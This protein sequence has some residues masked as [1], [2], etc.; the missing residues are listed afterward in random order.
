MKVAIL[1]VLVATSAASASA[2]VRMSPIPTRINPL[3]G[4]PTLLPSPL[5]GPLSG[6]GATLP[7][8]ILTPTVALAPMPFAPDAIA[9]SPVAAALPDSVTRFSAPNESPKS[10]AGDPRNDD[11]RSLFD[12]SR[13]PRDASWEPILPRDRVPRRHGLPEEELER[14]LGVDQR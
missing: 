13:D 8:P 7:A 9:G 10:D 5:N 1:T 11:L 2:M 3:A 6:L 14:E 4:L 12:G